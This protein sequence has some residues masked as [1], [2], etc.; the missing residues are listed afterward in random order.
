MSKRT[1]ESLLDHAGESDERKTDRA[2]T[3]AGMMSL[4]E[5]IDKWGSAQ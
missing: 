4:R 2:Y 3:E 1:N 5:Y